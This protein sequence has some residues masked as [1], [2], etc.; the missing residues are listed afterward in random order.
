MSWTKREFVNAAFEE[1]GLAAYVYDLTPDQLQAALRKLDSMMAT[2]NSKGIKLFY[3][4]PSS[5]GNSDLDENTGVPDRANEAI[6]TNLAIRIAP[7][8][9]KMVSQETKSTAKSAYDF[10][11]NIAAKPHEMKFPTNYPLGSGHKTWR[12]DDPFVISEGDNVII[13]PDTEAEFL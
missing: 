3:P 9:G 6:Y 2:W 8:F 4:L 10:L 7:S 13:G 1:I 12:Q 5:P 11:I